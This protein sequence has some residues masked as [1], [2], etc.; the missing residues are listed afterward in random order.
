MIPTSSYKEF[1]DAVEKND[2][3]LL[4]A[5]ISEL[6]IPNR[7]TL[8]YLC[9]HW[10]KVAEN[11]SV[12]QMPLENLATC[13]GP[14]IVGY[15]SKFGCIQSNTRGNQQPAETRRQHQVLLSLLKLNT[16]RFFI[17]F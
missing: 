1:I 15:S 10:Q 17:F 16:V 2:E 13:L 9:V 12:N 4:T 5:A 11:Q 3:E 6:P 7:D 8:A 14:T